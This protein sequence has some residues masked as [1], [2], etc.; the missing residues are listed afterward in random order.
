[1]LTEIGLRQRGRMHHLQHGGRLDGGVK[2]SERQYPYTILKRQIRVRGLYI[3]ANRTVGKV[4][5][6][7]STVKNF[8][9]KGSPLGQRQ[10]PKRGCFPQCRPC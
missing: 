8:G 3:S 5:R 1:M 10:T 7:V 6:G 9:S 4:G 2:G